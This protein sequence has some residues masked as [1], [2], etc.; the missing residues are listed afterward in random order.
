MRR[1]ATFAALGVLLIA[2]ALPAQAQSAFPSKFIKIIV[3]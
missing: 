2:T 1:L 3:G